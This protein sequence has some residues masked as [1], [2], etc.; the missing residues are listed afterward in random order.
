MMCGKVII[1]SSLLKVFKIYFDIVIQL[2]FLKNVILNFCLCVYL[3]VSIYT[4][5]RERYLTPKL[6]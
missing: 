5:A 1:P 3:W 2:F 4:S 6:F